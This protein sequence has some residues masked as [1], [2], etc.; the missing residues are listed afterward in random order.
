[1]DSIFILVGAFAVVIAFASTWRE[2]KFLRTRISTLEKSLDPTKHQIIPDQTSADPTTVVKKDNV[3]ST[4]D[5]KQPSSFISAAIITKQQPGEHDFEFETNA[6]ASQKK[7]TKRKISFEQNFGARLPVWI[8]G[9][10][11]AL[12][13][14][15]MVKYSIES[16]LLSPMVR[17]SL[18]GVFGILLL[19]CG[20]IIRNKP[21]IPN[22]TRISQALSGAGIAVL[23]GTFFSA[24]NLYGILPNSMSFIGMAIVT[25]IAVGLSLLHGPPIALLGL[26]GGFLT[27]ALIPSDTPSAGGLF[28]YL[29][30]VYA[31]IMFIIRRQGWW[32]LSLL[33][34]GGS[35]F[36]AGL[37]ALTMFTQGDGIALGFFIIAVCAI[38]TLASNKHYKQI[39]PPS[40]GTEKLWSRLAATPCAILNIGGWVAGL[41]L[42]ATVLSLDGYTPLHW[43]MFGLISAGA[44]ALAFYDRRLYGFTPWTALFINL[45]MLLI[46]GTSN[47][48]MLAGVTLGFGLLFAGAGS[49]LMWLSRHPLFWAVMSATAG[50]AYY[51]M[52]Y[53]L[54]DDKRLVTL[55]YFWGG[56]A[57]MLCLLSAFCTARIFRH[58]SGHP[59][60]ERLLAVFIGTATAFL[61]TAVTIELDREFLSVVFAAQTVVLAWLNERIMVPALRKIIIAVLIGFVLILLPQLYAYLELVRY[62]LLDMPLHHFS[63]LPFVQWPVFQL[64][65]PACLFLGT[66][67]LLQTRKDISLERTFEI[68]C[69]ILATIMAYHL[70]RH[71]FH[72]GENIYTISA[73]FLERGLTTNMFFAGGAGCLFIGRKFQRLAYSWCG[74]GLCAISLSRIAYFDLFLHSPL[75]NSVAVG[76]WPIINLLWLPFGITML[77]SLLA[78]REVDILQDFKWLSK[79]FGM[80]AVVLLFIMVSLQIRQFFHGEIIQLSQHTGD[81]EL[82]TYS[83]GWLLLGIAF[84]LAGTW[85][86]DITLRAI[87]LGVMILTIAKVF[88]LDAAELEG[89]YRVFSFLGLGISLLSLS[90]FYTRFVFRGTKDETD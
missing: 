33:A 76:T 55:P 83:V 15:F 72:A 46:W 20:Q 58:Y 74:I 48:T 73:G 35:L 9:I 18:S 65:I 66:A 4:T 54:L 8:G 88:L 17:V 23:Y 6:S 44:I 86:K 53:A 11:L 24:S 39:V 64:G 71:F 37:W 16:G 79:I 1:M 78:A 22:G 21:A 27:P 14:V 90:W 25:A 69:V 32:K 59:A 43:G 19:A 89:L 41:L 45:F 52:A 61:S 84:L 62:S 10:A 42:M 49:I 5:T 51:L 3:T 56:L 50:M 87:S 13:G 63:E 77:W 47:V 85:R 38:T 29:I 68:G 34:L 30:L 80:A 67:R 28:S 31:G 40:E 70:T 81:A 2:I 75:F 57:L 7:T 26:I 36:W 12:A 82:Y 60:Q